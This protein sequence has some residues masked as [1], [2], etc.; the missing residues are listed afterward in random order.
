MSSAQNNRINPKFIELCKA[1]LDAVEATLGAIERGWRYPDLWKV[2]GDLDCL[3][4]W[5]Q[6]IPDLRT[7][8]EKLGERYAKIA[9]VPAPGF[10]AK[11]LPMP[12]IIPST[13]P[14]HIETPI[15]EDEAMGMIAA[16]A[17]EGFPIDEDSPQTAGVMTGIYINR[18]FFDPGRL[19]SGLAAG[20]ISGNAE[21]R[22]EALL[23]TLLVAMSGSG[24]STI[25]IKQA[26]RRLADA[27]PYDADC[28]EKRL[29]VLR[30]E[31]IKESY[32]KRVGK[33]FWVRVDQRDSSRVKAAFELLDRLEQAGAETIAAERSDADKS[34]SG[35]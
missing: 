8:V 17:A 11:Y 13:R 10:P 5:T 23:Q 3:A 35:R 21:T 24:V 33:S 16:L 1:R 30:R 27:F 20:L 15:N 19:R 14:D 22:L 34:G 2:N 4:G 29:G 18:R 28:F 12:A 25:G 9:F 32:L 7:R 6:D 31:L 26:C